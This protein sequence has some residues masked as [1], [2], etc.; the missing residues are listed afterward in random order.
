MCFISVDFL[1]TNPYLV[2]GTT[3]GK[4]FAPG[5]K[6]KFTLGCAVK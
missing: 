6:T 5:H 2:A 1:L 3:V 4:R